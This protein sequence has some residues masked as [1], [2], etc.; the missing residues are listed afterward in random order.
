MPN[1]ARV[2][3]LMDQR[4]RGLDGLNL[5]SRHWEFFEA[6]SFSE[7]ADSAP[8]LLNVTDGGADN[9]EII[10]VADDEH[11]GALRMVTN[12][13]DNDAL[14]LQLN[15][16][17]V[18]LASNRTIYF[19]TRVKL[20][21]VSNTDFSVGLSVALSSGTNHVLAGVTDSIQFK[22]EAGGNIDVVAEK[23]ST[24]TDNDSG[25]D[26]ADD[27]YVK[28]MAE[29]EGTDRI[30]Y[31][32]DDSLVDTITNNLPDDEALAPYFEVRN[33]SAATS[34]LNADYLILAFE[35]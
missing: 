28:L 25:S 14:T 26:M 24:E 3:S 12:D 35:R 29:I 2:K 32:V 34:E 20:G 7:T 1:E 5:V 31:F 4:K 33:A 17:Q 9:A 21:D 19:V 27:T 6:P 11:A 13:A 16:E 10:S 22:A 18:A 15:G 30:N 8:W 23:D